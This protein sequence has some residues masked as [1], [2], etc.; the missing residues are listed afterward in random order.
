MSVIPW[1]TIKDI[2]AA[3]FAQWS[4]VGILVGIMIMFDMT[5]FAMPSTNSSTTIAT[6]SRGM[7][8]RSIVN[9]FCR[10]D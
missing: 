4:T 1:D 6:T 3:G 2:I 10:F 7:G 8:A 9:D 5:I